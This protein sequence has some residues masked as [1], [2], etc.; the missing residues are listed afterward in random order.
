MKSLNNSAIVLA[1]TA[2]L[3]EDIDL[4]RAEDAKERAVKRLATSTTEIDLRRAEY[5]LRRA[6]ARIN[7]SEVK[8]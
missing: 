5:A 8:K 1:D 4:A 3:A 7:A 2:E 6:S